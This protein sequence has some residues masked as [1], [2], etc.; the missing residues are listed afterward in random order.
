M[1]VVLLGPGGQPIHSE[2]DEETREVRVVRSD[3]AACYNTK[4]QD[5]A[6]YDPDS[7]FYANSDFVANPFNPLADK[8]PQGR[9]FE[10]LATLFEVSSDGET[11]RLQKYDSKDQLRE[12]YRRAKVSWNNHAGLRI[13][14]KLREAASVTRE[15]SIDRAAQRALRE[16]EA[17]LRE[18]FDGGRAG[19]DYGNYS[20]GSGFFRSRYGDGQDADREY[21]PLG[22]G[23]YYKQLYQHQFL[24]MHVQAFEAY[25]HNPIAKRLVNGMADFVL[26]RGI[27]HQCT[28]IDVGEVWNEFVERTGLYERLWNIYK[29]GLWSGETMFELYADT[30]EK[31][32]L[33]FRMIDPSSIREIA[34]D[35]DDMQNIFFYHQEYQEVMQQYLDSP[36][37]QSR[38]IIREIPPAHVMHIKFNCSEYEKRGRSYLFPVLGWCKRFKDLANARV[39]KG[40]LEAAFVY[41]V[42][43]NSGDA[44]VENIALKLPDPYK[45]GSTFV[46]NKTVKLTAVASSIKANDNQPDVDMLVN[47]IALGGGQPKELLGVVSRGSG[48]SGALLSSEPGTKNF[49]T[50]QSFAESRYMHGLANKVVACAIKGKLLDPDKVMVNARSIVRIGR[51]E[52]VQANPREEAQAA[53]EQNEQ[54]QQEQQTQQ[55]AQQQEQ[56]AQQA[57]QAQQQ[58]K[59]DGDLAV[60]Q[61][62]ATPAPAIHIHATKESIRLR[63]VGSLREAKANKLSPNQEKRQAT[64]LSTG[65]FSKEFFE[66]MF[67]A[68]AQEDRSAKLKDLALAE[69]MEWLSKSKV[70]T[71]AA[72]ELNVTTYNFE[73]EQ[74]MIREEADQGMSIAHVYGQDNKHAPDTVIAQDVQERDQA[75]QPPAQTFSNVPVPPQVAGMKQVPD[76]PGQ[77]GA[78]GG[79]GDKPNSGTSKTNKFSGPD[80]AHTDP[81][82]KSDGHSAAANSPFTSEGKAKLAAKAREAQR[83]A[84]RAEILREALGEL[85]QITTHGP[86]FLLTPAKKETNGAD[87]TISE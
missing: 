80:P 33:D 38:Y 21:L 64:I 14:G 6:T 76:Q 32:R 70:A 52:T 17:K 11:Y 65:Q 47:I 5:G 56:Q 7:E 41:D 87:A 75:Q 55:Q 72:K 9:P 16:A 77:Q 59:Q 53:L 43:V 3:L 1:S 45:A 79:P 86:T 50:N 31:G 85:A 63:G 10:V 44:N 34:T 39:V 29:D 40:Q 71:M 19:F 81:T 48:K 51:Q 83:R 37:P 20:P 15:E 82:K 46:H 73:E 58:T 30:P 74:A 69:S 25:N 4:V 36:V 13:S 28:D 57:Q 54:E 24:R 18:D 8:D 78:P 35:P 68:I 27:D 23:P 61:A 22:W 67:P 62:K 12:A 2:E 26:G 49:E 60:A 84:M 66:F 42:E